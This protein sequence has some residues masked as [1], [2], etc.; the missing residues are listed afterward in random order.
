METITIPVTGEGFVALTVNRKKINWGNLF[1]N[2]AAST[3]I[4]LKNNCSE[5]ITINGISCPEDHQAEWQRVKLF[6]TETK[7]LRI[8]TIP[9]RFGSLV[10]TIS[11]GYI[12]GGIDATLDIDL[13]GLIS[14]PSVQLAIEKAN[15]TR[16]SELAEAD[17]AKYTKRAIWT[18]IPGNSIAYEYYEEGTVLPENPTGSSLLKKKT[19]RVDSVPI[20]SQVFVY[21][22][23]KKV[24]LVSC[25]KE[26]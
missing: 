8:T 23:Q 5:I 25:L 18:S 16:A 20:Y 22:A 11:I 6:P 4:E 24:V 14:D 2:T 17:L 21:D 7:S 13:T 9:R 3:T 12:V 1:Y 10:D 19:F 15:K 26:T